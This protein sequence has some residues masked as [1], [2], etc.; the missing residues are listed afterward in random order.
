MDSEFV[1]VSQN[2]SCRLSAVQT[3]TAQSGHPVATFMWGNKKSLYTVPLQ[4]GIAIRDRLMQHYRQ[5]YSASC[6]CLAVLGGE[7]LGELQAC[8]EEIF[9]PVRC[10]SR[11]ARC[12]RTTSATAACAI[13]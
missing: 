11:H 12:Q 7:S 2:D 4:Q 6:M 8:V 1:G 13:A 9:G 3:A 10:R 5:Y